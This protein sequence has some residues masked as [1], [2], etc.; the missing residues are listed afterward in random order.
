MVFLAI[1][2]SWRIAPLNEEKIRVLIVEDHT[3]V[4]KGLVSLL[5]TPRFNIEIVGEA[6]D[7]VEAITQSGA[8]HPDVI[9]MD[10]L[11]PRKGGVEAIPEIK[12]HAQEARILVLTSFGEDDDIIAAIRA[13]ADGY[14][15][16]DCSPDEL[17][18]AIRGVHNG[19][20]TLP[21]EM[22]RKVMALKDEDEKHPLKE[23]LTSREMD[24]L[25]C[26]AQGLSN[27]EA[28][29]YLVISSHTIRS[30]MRNIMQKL[31]LK[32]RTQ[33]ALYAIEVGLM[34]E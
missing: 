18:Y 12:A 9:L 6:G 30:H 34:E 14:L 31:N 10:L 19:H 22:A 8:L 29:A 5:S 17:L 33:V 21:L 16:K 7:G 13:G 3:V 20:F 23:P 26:I 15:K 11:M 25:R 24:V 4:R 32:N 1:A 27:Q 2:E 28:A